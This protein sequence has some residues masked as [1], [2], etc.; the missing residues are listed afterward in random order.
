M[1]E[2]ELLM[3][4]SFSKVQVVDSIDKRRCGKP[5]V[6]IVSVVATDPNCMDGK[7]NTVSYGPVDVL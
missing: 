1:R 3:F 6:H 7:H 4:G 2:K 5:F